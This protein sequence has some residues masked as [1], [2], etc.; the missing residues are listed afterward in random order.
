MKNKSILLLLLCYFTNSVS[1]PAFAG[2][3]GSSEFEQDYKLVKTIVVGAASFIAASYAFGVSM[4]FLNKERGEKKRSD[5]DQGVRDYVRSHI[6]EHKNNQEAERIYENMGPAKPLAK[7]ALL[8]Y[9]TGYKH[10]DEIKQ[11]AEIIKD[12]VSDLVCD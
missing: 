9:K 12:T 4:G 11:T 7:P 3:R 8:G 5:P 2:N 1:H 6:I 10:H